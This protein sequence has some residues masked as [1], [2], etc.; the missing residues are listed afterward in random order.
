MRVLVAST[1]GAGHF[2]SVAPF[3]VALAGA[4]HEVL[5]AVPAESVAMARRARLESWVVG[6]VT[7]EQVGQVFASLPS[8]RP[9][10]AGPM[11]VRE[12]YGRL[13][14]PAALPGTRAAIRSFHPDLVLRET[15]HYA[16]ALAA[17][18]AGVPHVRV[19]PGMAS[20]DATAVVHATE[21]FPGLASAVASIARSPLLTFAPASLDDPGQAA[22]TVV[23]RYRDATVPEPLADEE[24]SWLWSGKAPLVYVT[25]GSV[26]SGSRAFPSL[27]RAAFAALTPLEVR[28]LVTVGER[29]DL[30]ALGSPPAN[31]RGA[32]WVPQA[33]LW[34]HASGMLCHGGFG[35]VLGGLRAGVPIVT[36]PM[37]SDQPRNAAQVEALGAGVNLT[38]A[39]WSAA[40]IRDALTRVL[41][42]G[43]YQAAA[44]RVAAEIS[45]LPPAGEAVE[46]L[47][48]EAG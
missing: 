26:A 18:E 8:D 13:H 7:R 11:L 21:G 32:R 1:R 22:L 9:A 30:S 14:T 42:N 34:Q 41:A 10:Q 16:S 44:R 5:A 20:V 36:M 17:E 47:R 24:R 25:F 2:M 40:G 27:I 4:G 19:A 31:V 46:F 15:F 12:L 48:Q 33:S 6:D 45:M 28:A 3:A 39:D 23:R 29:A 43:S 38:R 35:T 37:L